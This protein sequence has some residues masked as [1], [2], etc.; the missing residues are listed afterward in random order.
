MTSK[1]DLLVLNAIPGLNGKAVQRI[2]ESF[3][4]IDELFR[5]DFEGLLEF[6]LNQ[7]LIRN[8]L[9]F[10]KDKFLDAEYN[11]LQKKHTLLIS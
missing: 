4:S 9:H 3:N 1:E 2:M 10:P 6:G 5:Q 11:L 8:I 7:N